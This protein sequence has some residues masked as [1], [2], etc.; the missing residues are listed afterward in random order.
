MKIL[1]ETPLKKEK[2]K[3]REDINRNLL[4]KISKPLLLVAEAF[5]ILVQFK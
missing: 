1:V 3:L 2:E 5:L 4:L